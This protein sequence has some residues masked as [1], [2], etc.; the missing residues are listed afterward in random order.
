MKTND[1]EREIEGI[2]TATRSLITPYRKIAT[3]TKQREMR[4]D[5]VRERVN[6]L[7]G[8]RKKMEM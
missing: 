4:K 6:R 3:E 1:R 5:G 8:E 2:R 7:F